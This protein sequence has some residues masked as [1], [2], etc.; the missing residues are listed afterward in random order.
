M[1]AGPRQ[2]SCSQPSCP[3]AD[4]GACL[5]GLA[6]D[7]CPHF[8]LVT[9]RDDR[10]RTEGDDDAD[11]DSVPELSSA[12]VFNPDGEALYLSQSAPLFGHRMT[13]LIVILGAYDSGKTTL[14]VEIFAQFLKHAEFEGFLFSES[15]TLM[16]F[17][18]R[19]FLSRA[20][21]GRSSPTTAHTRRT[22][23]IE[24]LHLSVRDRVQSEPA[25]HLALTDIAG[26]IFR[27]ASSDPEEARQLAKLTANAHS[28]LVLV[29]CR[30]LL[31]TRQR[32]VHWADTIGALRGI[33]EC[34]GFTPRTRLIVAFSKYDLVKDDPRGLIAS[35]KR[36]L[37]SSLGE[38]SVSFTFIELA[39]RPGPSST[40]ERTRGL[41]R[42]F[43]AWVESPQP[44]VL[45]VTATSVDDARAYFV[46][47]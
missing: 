18:R 36:D 44:P 7:K 42:V 27:D 11:D 23:D 14:L 10:S 39:A 33:A 16:G 2:A 35:S 29:D 25:I 31:D 41:A 24:L 15:K 45:D 47:R 4:G 20:K 3:V 38:L 8:R 17:E 40:I 12:S 22:T 5:E 30:K 28:V 32:H 34:G 43:A 9:I 6:S 37:T 26:E 1:S 46:F 19:A 13:R 21:S